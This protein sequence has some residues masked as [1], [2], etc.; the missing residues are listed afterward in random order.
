MSKINARSYYFTTIFK[1]KS[2]IS[3]AYFQQITR[4]SLES[5]QKLLGKG[6]ISTAEFL[7]R[8]DDIFDCFT[9]HETVAMCSV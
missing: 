9:H 8:F 4:A 7:S 2:A 1:D 5:S 3:Y 6:V